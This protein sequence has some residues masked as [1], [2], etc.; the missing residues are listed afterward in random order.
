ML[1]C[2]PVYKLN[3]P[4]RP[5]DEVFTTVNNFSRYLI[6][7]YGLLYDVQNNCIKP[8]HHYYPRPNGK[9]YERADIIRDDGKK[10]DIRINRMVLMGFKPM[11]DYSSFD[12]HHIDEN[13]LNNNLKNL[14]WLSHL[15]NCKEHYYIE[16]NGEYPYTNEAIHLICQMLVNS[17]PYEQIAKEVFNTSLN[18]TIKSYITA[19]RLKKIRKD[20]SDQYI[21]PNKARNAA[22]FSDDEIEIICQYIVKGYGNMQIADMLKGIIWMI[23]AIHVTKLVH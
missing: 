16:N 17:V 20:I 21:F 12:S 3:L 23:I 1:L 7:N 5:H 4:N 13:T 10:L 22:L 2:K 6:S 9:C 15:D 18:D 14:K 8:T 11:D 19:I